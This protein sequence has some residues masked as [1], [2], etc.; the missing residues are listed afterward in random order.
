MF[1]TLFFININTLKVHIAGITDKITQN[2]L[3]ESINTLDPVFEKAN[4]KSALIHDG[5]IHF[6]IKFKQHFRDL[7]IKPIKISPGSP[8]MNPYAESWVS[9]IKRECLKN[10]LVIG[11]SHL[12]YLIH[13]FVDYYNNFR[14][15]SSKN[16]EPLTALAKKYD[17]QIKSKPFLG[18]LHHHYYREQITAM[19][20]SEKFMTISATRVFLVAL[21]WKDHGLNT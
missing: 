11:K 3:M 21:S 17:G 6:R 9:T 14:P 13:E 5:D 19:I 8:N 15:H 7:N 1:I 2:W 12:E 10:F 18:G 16:H 20:L 4:G